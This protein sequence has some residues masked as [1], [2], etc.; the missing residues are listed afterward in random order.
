MGWMSPMWTPCTRTSRR[1]NCSGFLWVCTRVIINDV[2]VYEWS[3]HVVAMW[4]GVVWVLVGL[5]EDE[6]C[7]CR[8]VFKDGHVPWVGNGVSNVSLWLPHRGPVWYM[9]HKDQVF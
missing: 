6:A 3:S 9:I 7:G 5:Y 4:E 8:S 1:A 2:D